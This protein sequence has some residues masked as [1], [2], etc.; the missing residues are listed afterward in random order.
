MRYGHA[1]TAAP[2]SVAPA[3]AASTP[4]E[5]RPDR[6]LRW[7]AVKN[8]VAISRA[9]V[10]RL[11]RKGT[12]PKREMLTDYCVGWRLSDVEAWVAGKRDWSSQVA[13]EPFR[14]SATDSR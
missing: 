2:R 12:F 8:L 14:R 3:A 7:P 11:E 5:R 13:G 10:D 9:T 4:S 1:P 6:M